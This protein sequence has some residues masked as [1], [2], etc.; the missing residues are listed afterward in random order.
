MLTPLRP[1]A[2]RLAR[3]LA[4]SADAAPTH[5]P[6]GL[7]GRGDRW[8]E[9]GPLRTGHRTDLG[10]GRAVFDR[11]RET[12]RTWGQFPAWATVHGGD[13]A[14]V[15]PPPAA[16]AEVCVVARGGGLWWSNPAR[17]YEVTDEPGR[18]GVAY[19]TLP[20][21]VCR[22]EERFGVSLGPEGRVWYDVRADSVLDHPLA[23]L[24][25]PLVRR[26]QKEF[27]RDSLAAM[28]RAVA[29]VGE[30]EVRYATPGLAA[31]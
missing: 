4:R 25:G 24:A 29:G 27:A 22:G 11:A 7:E 1:T 28:R 31:A 10:R 18:Y 16:G 30:E 19:A 6:G 20:G 17:I 8:A 2:D 3:L 14:G 12:L 21:H 9:A 15:P 5:I 23:K 26:R 13:C